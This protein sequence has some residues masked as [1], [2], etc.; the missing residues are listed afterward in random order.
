[1]RIWCVVVVLLCGRVVCC[2]RVW[3][4]MLLRGCVAG[5]LFCCF[6]CMCACL[7]ACLLDCVCCLF[8][9]LRVSLFWLFCC[10]VELLLC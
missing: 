3:F 8:V 1:M 7:F 10:V 6:V 5:L 9:C 2:V 4:V